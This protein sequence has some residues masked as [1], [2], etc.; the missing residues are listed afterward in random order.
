MPHNGTTLRAASEPTDQARLAERLA[1]LYPPGSLDHD[2]GQLQSLDSRL[3]ALPHYGAATRQALLGR[4]LHTG[5]AAQRSLPPGQREVTPLE[6]AVVSAI[7]NQ[8]PDVLRGLFLLLSD[9]QI[10]RDLTRPFYD[11]LLQHAR[12]QAGLVDPGLKALIKRYPYRAPRNADGSP[13][14]D[15]QQHIL[16]LNWQARL[17]GSNGRTRTE[18]AE[19]LHL[20]TVVV[21]AW[22]TDPALKFDFGNFKDI[23]SIEACV[24]PESEARFEALKASAA[25]VHMTGHENLGALIAGKFAQMEAAGDA[26]SAML[27]LTGNHAM[28]L[29][30]RIKQREGRP[31][32]VV[33]V[34]DPNRTLRHA[35][36]SSTSLDTF[37]RLTLSH[38]LDNPTMLDNYYPDGHGATMLFECRPGDVALPTTAAHRNRTLTRLDCALDSGALSRLMMEN[39]GGEI[40][41][42]DSVFA[43]MPE[44]RQI[45]VLQAR[46]SDGMR[47]LSE[48]LVAGNADALDA[49]G[50]WLGRVPEQERAALI[51]TRD[52]DMPSGLGRALSRAR[53]DAVRAYGELVQQTPSA[54]RA[55]LLG[56][57]D[58]GGLPPL[59]YAMR[60]N[61]SAGMRAMV[62]LIA[63]VPETDRPALLAATSASGYPGLFI[64]AH[65]QRTDAVRTFRDLLVQIPEG[66]RAALVAATIPDAR[67]ALHFAL[68]SGHTGVVAA[69]S[70]L[71][72]SVP[73]AQRAG[74]VAAA[75]PQGLHGLYLAAQ[76]NHHDA[77]RA[78][79][80]LL[81][82]VPEQE[83][84]ALVAATL[85]PD[86]VTG[87]SIAL[88]R[89]HVDV[90]RA[91]RGLL[92]QVPEHQRADLLAAKRPDGTS[93]LFVAACRGQ[94]AAIAAFAELRDLAP[95]EQSLGLLAPAPDGSTLLAAAE[96]SGD[97]ATVAIVRALE[98]E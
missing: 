94:A 92:E 86:G 42:L 40:R 83:R 78:Y 44:P 52:K 95:I 47:A 53:L 4:L 33:K 46:R 72:S 50:S 18:N 74:L 88:E 30:L 23:P 63:T 67:P 70:E 79:A 62:P 55:A 5:S 76:N 1:I 98:S 87:L 80:G 17:L 45:A 31:V 16:N 69:F 19:C 15:P 8:R 29:G 20:A 64:A 3:R 82:Q 27:L 14:L 24:G 90:I 10:E 48:A 7:Q 41:K 32:Y 56:G 25:E 35:R 6:R 39:F 68:L 84:A 12:H 11:S 60:E 13:V 73:P 61:S 96:Y 66:D 54:D 21:D 9:T 36:A 38:F 93:G 57:L 34:F 77:I 22:R 81:A 26:G 91:W 37:T 51:D 58:D 85:Q 75:T 43:A 97:A 2:D 59:H 49:F 28:A 71:I 65:R 89:G